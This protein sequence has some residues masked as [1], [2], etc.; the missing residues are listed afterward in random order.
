MLTRYRVGSRLCTLLLPGRGQ[1]ANTF[2][3]VVHII[4]HQYKYGLKAPN[5]SNLR[6]Q[7]GLILEDFYTNRRIG[8]TNENTQLTKAEYLGKCSDR[9]INRAY[10]YRQLM[11]EK[12]WTQ[13]ELARHLEVS[14]AWISKVLDLKD[15]IRKS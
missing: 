11:K 1:K 15:H 9:R 14:R 10:E 8:K 5:K 2:K 12:G 13:A 4:Y 7:N 6:I 3:I